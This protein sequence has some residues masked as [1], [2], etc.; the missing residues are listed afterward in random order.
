MA[1]GPDSKLSDLKMLLSTQGFV[2][3][4]SLSK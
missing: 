2:C 4:F 3:F 1:S